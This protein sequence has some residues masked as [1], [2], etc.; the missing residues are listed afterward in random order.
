LSESLYRKLFIQ[1]GCHPVTTRWNAYN[2][3]WPVAV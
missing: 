3:E 2:F 1:T